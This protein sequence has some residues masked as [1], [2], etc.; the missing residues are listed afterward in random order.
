[1]G[2]GDEYVI[3]LTKPAEGLVGYSFEIHLL[4]FVH[5]YDGDHMT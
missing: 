4:K 5:E 3:L 2:P 1:M